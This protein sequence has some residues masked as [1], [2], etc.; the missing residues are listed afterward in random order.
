MEA[1]Q[2]GIVNTSE[3]YIIPVRGGMLVFTKSYTSISTNASWQNNG[4]TSAYESITDAI[5]TMFKF[6]HTYFVKTNSGFKL[7]DEKLNSYLDDVMSNLGV[8]GTVTSGSAD[9]YVKDGRLD[10]ASV[11]LAMQM[12][13][14][15]VNIKTTVSAT[16]TYSDY[17]TTV[18]TIPAEITAMM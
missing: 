4:I 12:T 15:G 11:N 8:Y 9:Y 7:S 13:Q 14:S 5:E 10:G 16:T 2:N 1:T 18:I 3:T 6:D 17:G